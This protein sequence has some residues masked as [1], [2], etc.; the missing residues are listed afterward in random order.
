MFHGHGSGEDIAEKEYLLEFFRRR[1]PRRHP[2]QRAERVARVLAA[3]DYLFPIYREG[4]SYPYLIEKGVRGN[5][6]GLRPE[7][8][9]AQAL[10]AMEPHFREARDLAADRYR[11]RLGTGLA[12]NNMLEIVPAAHQGRV[13]TLFVAVGVQRYGVFDPANQRVT[14]HAEARPGDED[15]LNLA[16]VQAFLHG[17]TVYAVPPEELPDRE[18]LAAVFRY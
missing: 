2:R 4:N 10:D 5:P 8:L 15:L 13:E 17:G 18:P 16:A 14:S 6:E 7:D 1:G 3:V 12:S 9:H 11:E